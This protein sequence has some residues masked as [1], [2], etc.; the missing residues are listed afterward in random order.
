MWRWSSGSVVLQ[1]SHRSRD[2]AA[3]G[4]AVRSPVGAWARLGERLGSAPR[5]HPHPGDDLGPP[6]RRDHRVELSAHRRPPPSDR[7]SQPAG[8]EQRDRPAAGAARCRRRGPRAAGRTRSR[9]SRSEACRRRARRRRAAPRTTRTRRR[10]RAASRRRWRARAPRHRRRARGAHPGTG[11]LERSTETHRDERS[12]S[13]VGSCG[14]EC[15]TRQFERRLRSR[16]APS[17]V[18]RRR[19]APGSVTPWTSRPA[20]SGACSSSACLIAS[21]SVARDA[22]QPLQLPCRTSLATPS[23]IPIS[24]T[25]PPWDSM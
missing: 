18:P 10:T 9:S 25:L 13:D 15:T 23:S 24:S 20:R 12:G 8:L 4:V 16:S 19:G 22:A 7:H 1:R 14:P 5:E 11:S 17:G 6:P 2:C 21:S 3:L